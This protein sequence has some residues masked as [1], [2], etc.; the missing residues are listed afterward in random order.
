MGSRSQICP[1]VSP[2]IFAELSEK[3]SSVVA[4][5]EFQQGLDRNA[6]EFLAV[7]QD[8]IVKRLV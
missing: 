3:T 1:R 2:V 7:T 8:G 5:V 4:G 6:K